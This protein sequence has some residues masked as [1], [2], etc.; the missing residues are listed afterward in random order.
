MVIRS[1]GRQQLGLF[2]TEYM[3]IVVEFSGRPVF[4]GYGRLF[5]EL[6]LGNLGGHV[7][8]ERYRI[9]TFY[10]FHGIFISDF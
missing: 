7:P 9:V 1:S 3:E 4:E 10:L 6:P 2:Y 5:L 8:R